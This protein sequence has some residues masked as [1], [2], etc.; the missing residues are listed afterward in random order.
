MG[1]E[2]SAKLV[3]LFSDHFVDIWKLFS[4]TASFLGRT[5]LFTQYEDQ[6]RAWRRELQTSR[7]NID[8]ARRIRSELTELRKLL[9]LQGYD[10]SLAKQR[11]VFEGFRNDACLGEGFKR[12]VIFFGDNDIYWLTGEDNHIMLAQFLERQLENRS[13]DKKRIVIRGKHYLWYR[14]RG[15]DLVISG[16]DTE[17]K[18]DFERLKAIGEA[19]SLYI[20]GKLKGLR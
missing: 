7:Q 19:N 3:D 5:P 12:A 4:E 20:L 13:T 17:M 15:S 14:R 1:R 2:K 9:R 8:V 6:L 18:D 10:L 11:L 16:S